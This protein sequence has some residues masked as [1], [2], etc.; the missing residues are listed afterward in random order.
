MNMKMKAMIKMMLLLIMALLYTRAFSQIGTFYTEKEI[1]SC[2]GNEPIEGWFKL[3]L[4]DSLYLLSHSYL[5]D[6]ILSTTVFS[7]GRCLR[8][9]QKVVLIDDDTKSQMSLSIASDS[10]LM[11]NS[12]FFCLKNKCFCYR[13]QLKENWYD[14]TQFLH[15]GD[16]FNGKENSGNGENH[17][18]KIKCGIYKNKPQGDF[19]LIILE[20]GKYR[21]SYMDSH[22]VISRGMWYEKNNNLVLC[23]EFLTN[24]IEISVDGNCLIIGCLPG[25]IKTGEIFCLQVIEDE[26]NHWPFEK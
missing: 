26:A 22:F 14:E 6:D 17:T 24:P 16:K 5:G 23:D 20:D 1:I 25:Y 10:C 11:F 2:N 8:E 3:S 12:G 21:Y 4:N 7:Y 19:A 18:V 15:Q 9:G 13:N